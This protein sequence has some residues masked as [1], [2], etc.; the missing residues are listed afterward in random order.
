MAKPKHLPAANGRYA[1]DR[2]MS[3]WPDEGWRFMGEM[4]FGTCYACGRTGIELPWKHI[5]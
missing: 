5:E 3:R 4:Q 2:C 1:C